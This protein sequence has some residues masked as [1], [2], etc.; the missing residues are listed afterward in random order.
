MAEAS[1]HFPEAFGHFVD[2]AVNGAFRVRFNIDGTEFFVIKIGCKH[3]PV[4][5]LP[6]E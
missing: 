1:A 2:H 4:A 3:E 6:H 5:E